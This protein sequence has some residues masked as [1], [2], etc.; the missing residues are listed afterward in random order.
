MEKPTETDVFR[1]LTPRQEAAVDLLFSGKS[2]TE[3]AAAL[4]LHRT[5]VSGWRRHHP[6]FVAELNRRR[7]ELYRASSDRLRGMVSKALDALELALKGDC[8][9]P[10][11]TLILKLAAFDKVERPTGHVDAECVLD[12]LVVA[13][14]GQIQ[15]EKDRYITDD[16]KAMRRMFPPTPELFTREMAEAREAVFQELQEICP[17][18][19]HE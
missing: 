3:T 12:E 13:K 7:Q 19:D 4:G 14:R 1:H 9:I 8:P 11:V 2:D 15:Q 16:Q 6:A 5:T 17:V 10:S 18:D